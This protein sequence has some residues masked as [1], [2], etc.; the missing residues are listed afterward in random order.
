MRAAL[1]EA[2]RR[3]RVEQRLVRAPAA[4][5]PG[6]ELRSQRRLQ[7]PVAVVARRPD[8]PPQRP[9]AEHGKVVGRSRSEPNAELLDLELAHAGDELEGITQQLIRAA[10]RG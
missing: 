2:L 1:A 7:D 9:G 10:R 4:E 3:A 6:D 8:E 5:Q